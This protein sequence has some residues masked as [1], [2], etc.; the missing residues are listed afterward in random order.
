LDND[1]AKIKDL[2]TRLGCRQDRHGTISSTGA[3]IPASI[4][5]LFM[6]RRSLETRSVRSHDHERQR[7]R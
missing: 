2:R 6:R 7:R 1:A 3:S 4:G 5:C